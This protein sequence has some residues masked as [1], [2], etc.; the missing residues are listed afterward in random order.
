M[1]MKFFS[2]II[3]VFDEFTSKTEKVFCVQKLFLV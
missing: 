3:F 1:L 2:S